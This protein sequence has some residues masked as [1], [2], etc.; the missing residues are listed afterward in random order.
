MSLRGAQRRGNLPIYRTEWNHG[1]TQMNTDT[2]PEAGL[3]LITYHLSHVAA[4]SARSIID[5]QFQG[6]AAVSTL[7]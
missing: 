2:R 1:C 6:P 5:N 3:S 4:G 7:A